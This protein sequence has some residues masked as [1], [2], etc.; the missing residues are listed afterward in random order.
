M[1]AHDNDRDDWFN[2]VRQH[3]H[4]SDKN[5]GLAFC[6]SLLLGMLGADRFYL[7]SAWLGMLKLCT[8]GGGGI[9]WLAD[10]VLLLVGT[11]KDGEGRVLKKQLHRL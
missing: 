3:T 2:T 5:W 11:M 6:L 10:I 1:S 7:N 9:W 8:C 4:E